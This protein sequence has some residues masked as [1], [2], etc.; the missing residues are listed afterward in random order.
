MTAPDSAGLTASGSPEPV[1]TQGNEQRPRVLISHQ[2]CIPVY[3]KPLFE[4]LSRIE[5]IDYVVAYGDPPR[6][7][8]YIVAPPPHAFQSLRTQNREMAIGSTALIWQPLVAKFWGGF[9]A[10]VLGDEIKY[11]SHLAI[12][13][14]ARLRRRPVILWGFGYPAGQRESGNLS[15]AARLERGLKSVFRQIELR[16]IDGYLVYTQSGADSLIRA[17]L[18][19]DRIGTVRNTIDVEEQVRLRG[20]TMTETNAATREH[21][22]VPTHVP[23]FLYFGRYLP[24]KCVHLLI[25]Y[26]KR[27]T[28]RGRR[29]FV[30][31]S[32]TGAEYDNLVARAAGADNVAFRSLFDLELARALKIAS[33]VVIPGFSGLAIPHAFAHHVPFLTREGIVHPPEIDYLIPGENG[34][35]LPFEEEAFFDALDRY[36]DDPQLQQ[37]L[38][39]GAREAASH[40]SMDA[41]A[42]SFDG[43]VRR[44]LQDRGRL[45]RHAPVT[46]ASELK[47]C[48]VRS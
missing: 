19:P 42:A 14:A 16:L 20:I 29:V 7:T 48:G 30:M 25:D 6:G 44:L 4:R 11:L 18:P 13:A 22:G 23:V 31:L 27:C 34:L 5:D 28:A 46:P 9:D 24:E 43:L 38:R 17:G 8:D 36:L 45:P 26:A 40:L 12:I 35:L 21:L 41:M 10:A 33:A 1:G 47:T 3:R 15:R 39:T 2:G 37:R 32:G